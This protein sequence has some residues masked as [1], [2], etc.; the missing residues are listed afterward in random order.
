MNTTEKTI[1]YIPLEQLEFDPQ[2]PR[3]PATVIKRGEQAVLEWMLDDASILELMGSIGEQGYF[4]GEPLLVVQSPDQSKYTVIEGNRRLTAA[5]LLLNPNDAPARKVSIQKFSDEAK[6]KPVN[7]PVLIY[8]KREDII[9]YL[10]YRH[11]T[12]IK[13]WDTLAKAKYLGQL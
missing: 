6:Q 12:G 8:D 1:Q 9:N 11:I 13:Q 5:K 2:N 7:L 4:A 3:I 10:S